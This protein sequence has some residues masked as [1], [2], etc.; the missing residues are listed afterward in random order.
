MCLCVR[1][2]VQ[3]CNWIC[4]SLGIYMWIVDR[5]EQC[6]RQPN[7]G[8]Y[9]FIHIQHLVLLYSV[10]GWVNFKCVKGW[11]LHTF[12]RFSVYFIW[13]GTVCV[14]ARYH[15]KNARE[16]R[17]KEA[18][19]S[20]EQENHILWRTKKENGNINNNDN[21]S[22]RAKNDNSNLIKTRGGAADRSKKV[23]RQKCVYYILYIM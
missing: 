6:W 15:I 17:E 18:K 14:C 23:D 20:S 9:I 1:V 21:N 19:K 2:C 10:H 16:T 11:R 7:Q 13:I 3:V 12:L 5:V 4:L 8:V 22:D